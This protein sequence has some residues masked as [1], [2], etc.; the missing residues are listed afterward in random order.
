MVAGETSTFAFITSFSCKN[1]RNLFQAANATV[2][3]AEKEE[4]DIYVSTIS[5][6]N[7]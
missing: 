2:Y 4:G 7:R 5:L 1:M 3:N 6:R